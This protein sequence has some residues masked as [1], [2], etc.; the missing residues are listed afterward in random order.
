MTIIIPDELA[1]TLHAEAERQGTTAEE[2]ALWG[3]RIVAHSAECERGYDLD[4]EMK[5]LLNAKRDRLFEDASQPPKDVGHFA[6]D[7]WSMS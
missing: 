5:A 2:L 7:D 1:A 4:D 6:D 3:V